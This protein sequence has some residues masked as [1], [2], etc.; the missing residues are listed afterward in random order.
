MND[1]DIRKWLAEKYPGRSVEGDGDEIVVTIPVNFH[2]RNGRQMI[3]AQNCTSNAEKP[4]GLN[5]R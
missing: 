4:N 1:E 5:E 3:Q 2:R